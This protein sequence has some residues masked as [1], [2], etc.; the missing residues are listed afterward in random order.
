MRT[1]IIKRLLVMIPTLIGIV[2][3]SF[4]VIKLAPGDP[5]AQKFGGVGQASGGM[6]AERGTEAAEK[7]FRER[8]HFDDPWYI[9][10]GS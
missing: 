8:F 5:S 6:D 7:R 3:V 1:Y 2:I 9:Q 10:F 4:F